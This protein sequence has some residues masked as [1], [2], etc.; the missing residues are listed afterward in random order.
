M[1]LFSLFSLWHVKDHSVIIYTNLFKSNL[2]NL[3]KGL[4]VEVD[5]VFVNYVLIN[6]FNNF[7]SLSRINQ[8]CV[9]APISF[10]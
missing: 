8:K 6:L 9:K 7:P 3:R 1:K 2:E 10:K 4:F 5:Y